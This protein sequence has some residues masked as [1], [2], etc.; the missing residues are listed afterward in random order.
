[1]KANFDDVYTGYTAQATYDGTGTWDVTE[2]DLWDSCDPMAQPETSTITITQTGSD[3]T[4]V[5]ED[6]NTHT[7]TVSGTYNNLYGEFIDSG[8]TRKIYIAFTL[9]SSTS[10]NGS[11]YWEWTDGVDWCEGVGLFTFTKQA[12]PPAGGG[13]GGGGGCFIATAAYGSHME[14][15]VKTLREFRDRFLLTNSVGKVFVDLYYTY[16]PP[17]ADFI[18]RHET[19]QAAVRLSLLPVVGVSWMSLNTG[20]SVNLLLIGLLICFMGV[21]ATIALRR[22]RHRSQV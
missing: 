14:S 2:T 20:L 3:V 9:S 8:G 7:G 1:M 15:H 11:Y 22:M 17:V 4:L 19:L 13:G 12:A 21:S 10:G 5:D 6:G 18:A 16:S